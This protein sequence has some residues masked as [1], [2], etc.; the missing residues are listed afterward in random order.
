MTQS[1]RPTPMIDAHIH[2]VPGTLKYLAEIMEANNLSHVVNLGVLEAE[3]IPFQEGMRAFGRLLGG[4][5]VYFPAPDFS[6]VSPGFGGRMAD[7]L[8]RKVEAGAAGLKIFKR[9]GLHHR[10]ADGN[11]IPVDAIWI[12][13][14]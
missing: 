12:F 1:G 4:R 10:D 11:L 5:M 3:G 14:K 6:D 9:L 13:D 2:A 7:E 8:E